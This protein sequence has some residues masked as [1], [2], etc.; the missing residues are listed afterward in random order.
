MKC[1][2]KRNSMY[3]KHYLGFPGLKI[4]WV[5]DRIEAK[6]FNSVAEARQTIKIYKIKNV[7]VVKI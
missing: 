7:E 2:I 6:L 4:H 3:Y 1:F 5:Q